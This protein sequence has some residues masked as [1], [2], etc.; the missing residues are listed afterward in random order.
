MKWSTYSENI[1]DAYLSTPNNLIIQACPGAG[2]TTNIKH[3]WSLDNKPTVYL[4]FNKHNQ[5]EAQGKL[6]QKAGSDVLTLNG[7]GHRAVMNTFGKVT[8]DDKKVMNIIRNRRSRSRYGKYSNVSK[9]HTER[10]YNL[11]RAVAL[12]KCVDTGEGVS[13]DT[14]D[15]MLST[16]DIDSYPT[17]Y[18]DAL[19]VLEISDTTT[20]TIDYADQL[21]FPVIYKCH[22]P[23]YTNVLGDEVQDFNPVQAKLISLIHAQRYVLVGDAHQSIY[24]F[25]GAMNNS[26]AY[27]KEV[28]HCT[29]YPLSITYR[30]AKG[31]VVEAQKV[32]RDIEPW[33]K[34]PQG[35][36]RYSEAEKEQYTPEDIV[37]CRMNRPLIA[38]AYSL[39]Q[40]GIPCH[41]RGRDIGQGLVRLIKKHTETCSDVRQLMAVLTAEQDRECERAQMKDDENLAQR[42]EDKY[43]SALL[44]CSKRQ[45]T[46]SPYDV[47]SDIEQMFC[48][49]KGVCL[50]TVHKAKGLEADRALLLD[51][52]LFHA[53]ATR[54]SHP[55]QKEQENNV[56]YVALT[57]GKRELVYM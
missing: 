55:W 54:Q 19:E 52:G 11:A 2:K 40:A 23:E 46:D 21:R 8:L 34:S 48:D 38:L 36:V 42:I 51:T 41:V 25:R 9:E 49:G 43:T 32:Y 29:E 7:L 45:L 17:M 33:D 12:M 3:I 30:C 57:R 24:G 27:L 4:V 14:F 47:M 22:M 39:L 53:C 20:K 16:Y 10:E 28:F 18:S 31:I 50:T 44:F 13:S 15:A 6:S 1:F 35:V 56:L 37:L 26:M 5:L